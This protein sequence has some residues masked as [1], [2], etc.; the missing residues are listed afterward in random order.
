MRLTEYG[1]NLSALTENELAALDSVIVTGMTHIAVVD[2]L[3]QTT[4]RPVAFYRR[5]VRKRVMNKVRVTPYYDAKLPA[6][7]GFEEVYRA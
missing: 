7:T 1:I 2:V 5:V 3:A 6:P 4:G